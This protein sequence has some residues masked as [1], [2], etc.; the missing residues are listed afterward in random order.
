LTA[1]FSTSVMPKGTQMMMRGFT[2]V[3]RLCA[4]AM[5]YRSI[6]SVISKSA[7]TPSRRGR[8]ARM[9]PGV[10]PS[11]SLASRPTART[12]LPPRA[13]RWTATTEGSHETIPLPFT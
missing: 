5:K 12:L 11:I 7:M 6:A 13:S 2:S 1:R 3:R 10:R 4:R 8:T 9:L